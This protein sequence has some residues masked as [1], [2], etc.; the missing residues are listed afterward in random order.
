MKSATADQIVQQITDLEGK[1]QEQD[2][3]AR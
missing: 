3:A 2:G 1:G